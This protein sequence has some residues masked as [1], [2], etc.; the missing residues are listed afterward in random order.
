MQQKMKKPNS[1]PF[2]AAVLA[3]GISILTACSPNIQNINTT[4]VQTKRVCIADNCFNATV[5]TTTKR[6][7][8]GDALKTRDIPGEDGFIGWGVA[9]IEEDGVLLSPQFVQTLIP[10]ET[11]PNDLWK[12]HYGREVKVGEFIHS[13]SI[14]A[15]RGRNGT[16]IITFS[17]TIPN[18]LSQ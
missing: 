11:N 16:A 13:Y 6:V 5:K 7:K 18:S 8:E 1:I 2:R 10:R 12:V 14:K 3:A 4:D 9:K 15:E 17:S